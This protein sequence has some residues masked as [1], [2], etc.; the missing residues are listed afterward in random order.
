M[1]IYVFNR[2]VLTERLIEDAAN[3]AS[4]H[5]FGYSL[6]PAMVRRDRAF[7]YRFEGYWQDIGTIESYYRAN[8]ELTRERPSFSLNT[9][10]P[11]MTRGHLLSAP[12]IGEQAVVI[13]SLV[14]PGCVVRGRVENSVLS[15]RVWVNE[16]AVVRNSIIMDN[17]LIGRHS[18][19][20][21]CVLDEDVKVGDY[22]YLGFGSSLTPGDW[23]ITVIGKEV[24]VPAH[25]AIGRNCKIMPYVEGSDFFTNVIKSGSV[26]SRSSL[27]QAFLQRR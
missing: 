2:K 10:E 5:D 6:L 22:C 21:R 25:T 23:D 7:A 27:S 20:D 16:Q 9:A 11:V 24:T 15:P 4:R 3:P 12:R 13:N 14:S 1:G 17:T 19:V 26:L 8:M 18:V